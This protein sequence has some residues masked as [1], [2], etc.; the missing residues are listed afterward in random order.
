LFSSFSLAAFAGERS[1]T[2]GVA[3]LPQKEASIA[4]HER[5]IG[6]WDVNYEIYDKS[7]TIRH[8]L[9]QVTYSWL[10]KG[11]ALQEVWSGDAHSK[12]FIPYGAT[13]AFFDSKH[14]LWT[15]V[16]IYPDQGTTTVVS[17]G[18]AEGRIV[19]TGRNASG[20]LERWST[21]DIQT[22]SFVS[23]FEISEDEGKTWRLVGIN[24]NIRHGI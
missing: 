16:W 24:H 5:F 17:G 4:L 18:E 14:Q 15:E 8:N 22:N 10:I 2:G 13:I 21:S 7:G 3:G 6:T 19:L 23:R 12:E 9:G 1:E 20:A 11:Q